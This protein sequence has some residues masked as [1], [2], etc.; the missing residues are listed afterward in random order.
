MASSLMKQLVQYSLC[1]LPYRLLHPCVN[2]KVLNP[3]STLENMW[4]DEEKGEHSK[5]HPWADRP[6]ARYI[7]LSLF[8]FPA[9]SA[10]DSRTCANMPRLDLNLHTRG[11]RSFSYKPGYLAVAST[12]AR[13]QEWPWRNCQ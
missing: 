11:A 4:R 6:A 1:P 8:L 12:S 10:S 5:R 9:P 13:E 7:H 2:D 3:N